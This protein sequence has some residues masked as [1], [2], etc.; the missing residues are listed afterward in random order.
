MATER[1]DVV[2][3]YQWHKKKET[4]PAGWTDAVCWDW[5]DW[6]R[7]YETQLLQVRLLFQ[8]AHRKK[9]GRRFTVSRLFHKNISRGSALRLFLEAWQGRPF[10]RQEE[11]GV[12][13]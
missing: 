10:T 9:N 13:L 1:L 6:G 5:R 8:V 11:K 4:C 7:N 3:A 2:S 12:H